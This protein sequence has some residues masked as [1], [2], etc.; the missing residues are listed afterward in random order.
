VLAGRSA[1]SD[2]KQPVTTENSKQTR[3]EQLITQAI[4]LFSRGGY[5]ETSL[6]EIADRLGITR[7]LFYYYFESKEDLLWRIIGHLGDELLARA[8]PLADAAVGPAEKLRLLLEGHAETI[9]SNVAAFKIY[10]AERH[11][12]TGKR[13]RGMRQGENA[14][15]AII[16][17]VIAQGQHEGIFKD[18]DARLL[19][20]LVTGM[21]TSMLRWFVP[22]G[23]RSIGEMAAMFAGVG[24][25]A[26]SRPGSPSAGSTQARR[27]YTP[28]SPMPRNSRRRS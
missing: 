8:R 28:S 23:P 16:T 13:H 20:L 17:D 1:D 14:Y 26:V 3:V 15:L 7:P 9:L 11:L 21:G 4:E 22:S 2:G 18:G 12:V 25:D 10:E 27:D 5:R 19:A 24:V 6:Q